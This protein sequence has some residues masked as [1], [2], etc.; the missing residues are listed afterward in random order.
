M[1]LTCKRCGH[2]W[3][4]KGKNEYY[5]TCPYCMRKVKVLKK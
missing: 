4:Y 5:A 2:T 3:D 1:I